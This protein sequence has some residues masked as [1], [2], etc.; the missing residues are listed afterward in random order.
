MNYKYQGFFLENRFYI[1]PP[2]WWPREIHVISMNKIRSKIPICGGGPR[3]LSMHD[4]IGKNLRE[5]SQSQERF[6]LNLR[7]IKNR[8]FDVVFIF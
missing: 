4:M 5:L 7:G 6:A 3:S 1:W 8:F 2:L